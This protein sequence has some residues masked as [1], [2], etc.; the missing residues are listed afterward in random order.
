MDPPSCVEG[1]AYFSSNVSLSNE[2][3]PDTRSSAEG[4]S[5]NEGLDE[6]GRAVVE[7]VFLSISSDEELDV[8]PLSSFKKVQSTPSVP[9]ILTSPTNKTNAA[10]DR[11]ISA[12]LGDYE[13]RVRQEDEE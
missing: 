4:V 11:A 1:V 12:L 9:V 3:D 7:E 10:L 13:D 8:E 5:S 6:P 2:D